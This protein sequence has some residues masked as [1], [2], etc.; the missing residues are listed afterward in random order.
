MLGLMLFASCKKE[1]SEGNFSVY[2]GNDMN[3]TSWSASLPTSAAI[4]RII[5][6]TAIYQH[7]D[8]LTG[9]NGKT[10][11]FSNQLKL[12]FPPNA[13]INQAGILVSGNVEIK[14]L[15]MDQK[16][17]F[18]RTLKSTHNGTDLLETEKGI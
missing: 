18:V 4:H 13:F 9:A 11:T 1:V 3:D 8:S 17:A 15:M 10:I 7:Q 2:A 14:V 16:A 5:D 12:I 6:S